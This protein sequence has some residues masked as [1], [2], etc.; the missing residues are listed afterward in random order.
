[1]SRDSSRLLLELDKQ[2]SEINRHE[3]NPTLAEV[4]IDTI[5]PVIKVC[6]KARARYIACLMDV[7][8]SETDE[9]CNYEQIEQLREHRLTYEELVSA[10][11]ALETVVK[12]GYVDVKEKL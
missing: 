12:R 5:L 1:M 8:N 3:I 7:A 6:A 2:R 4:D 10:A 9:T 11:N